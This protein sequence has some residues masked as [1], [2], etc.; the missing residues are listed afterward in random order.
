MT[1]KL[2]SPAPTHA[3]PSPPTAL[4][5][6]PLNAAS[7]H[8]RSCFAQHEQRSAT[9]DGDLAYHP[10][11]LIELLG[12]AV[13]AAIPPAL[14]PEPSDLESQLIV[15][16]SGKSIA[17]TTFAKMRTISATR[18][19]QLSEAALGRPKPRSTDPM[20]RVISGGVSGWGHLFSWRM[21]VVCPLWAC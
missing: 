5:S 14:L 20:G 9:A 18:A 3:F 6:H 19:L 16:R 1:L 2:D 7:R 13:V 15:L 8:A 17:P 10:G 12:K 4:T 21:V 11:A